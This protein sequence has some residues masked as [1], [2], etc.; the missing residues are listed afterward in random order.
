M[1]LSAFPCLREQTKSIIINH[2]L[3]VKFWFLL[4]QILKKLMYDDLLA[5]ADN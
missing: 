5:T 1:K 3:S 4:N 2:S